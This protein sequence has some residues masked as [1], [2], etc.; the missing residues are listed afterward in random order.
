MVYAKGFGVREVGKPDTVNPDTVFQ[1]ASLSKSLSATC[2]A[3]AVTDK[4][5]SWSDPVTESL[6]TSP[7]PTRRPPRWRTMS[8]FF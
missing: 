8:N 6:P 3:K 7:S 4:V 5:V 1:I 2:V